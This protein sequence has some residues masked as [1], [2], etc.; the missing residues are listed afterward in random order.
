MKDQK[1]S[2]NTERST[3]RNVRPRSS[4]VARARAVI[5]LGLSRCAVDGSGSVR[6]SAGAGAP[7]PAGT[8]TLGVE[9]I[10]KFAR[11]VLA[12]ELEENLLEPH[13]PRLRARAQVGHRSTGAYDA[14][15]DDRDPVA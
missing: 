12:C 15:L 2:P 9:D 1:P 13:R 6:R 3:K 10:D 7:A 8:A 5:H 14:A 11:R 4:A